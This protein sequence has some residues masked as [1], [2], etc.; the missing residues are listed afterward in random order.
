MLTSLGIAE[1]FRPTRWL[2]VGLMIVVGLMYGSS[3]LGL[4]AELAQLQAAA[5]TITAD[6]L[7][8]HVEVL[9]DD[10][11]EGRAAGS[12][13]GYA[14]A[15]Y[16]AGILRQHGL[17]PAGDSGTYF[18]LF[19]SGY[20][21]V[22]ALLPGSDQRWANQ[23]IVIG[24][25]YDHVG[26]GSRANSFGPIGYIHNGADDNASGVAAVLEL[27][28]AYVT[29][30]LRP[31]RS[32]LFAFWDAEE[33]GLLG[34]QYW[35][36]QAQGT[37]E[38]VAAINLDMVGRLRHDHVEVYG[39]RSAAGLRQI[40]AM[41]NSGHGLLLSFPWEM[42]AN[43]DHFTFFQHH[44]PSMMFHTGLHSDYH[45]PTD[46]VEKINAA[47]I[48]KVAQLVLYVAAAIADQET[49][50][51][52]RPAAMEE[53]RLAQQ[54]HE[55]IL[56]ASPGRLGV[57]WKWVETPERAVHLASGSEDD[58]SPAPGAV[59]IVEVVPGSAAERAGLRPG[60]WIVAA[61]DQRLTD[62]GQFVRLV[63]QATEKIQLRVFQPEQQT[64]FNV[65]M[66]LVGPP[67]RAGISWKTNEAE[68]GVFYI[69]QVQPG[70]PADQAGLRPGD[71]IYAVDGRTPLS[72][73]EL[74]RYVAEAKG[75]MDVSAERH[76]CV[77]TVTLKLP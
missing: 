30:G 14:A 19:Q 56:P 17:L 43:S 62:D 28:D 77:R 76:G 46:D 2:P 37:Y 42:K 47:G 45:R 31:R 66:P 26:F 9:A 27:V 57:R 52:F 34:S 55:A 24:A 33:K 1:Y 60:Q 39:T 8:H 48:A 38:I 36:Q 63:Y 5:A 50:L 23:V 10:T 64:V 35:L 72:S 11:F 13:G 75:T 6:E 4:A 68:P 59:Q 41:A 15:N 71:R 18:Q 21:N 67:L 65:T 7:R 29:S 3:G 54:A 25:H 12:R 49:Q 58:A 74:Q 20:R 69:I 70:S 32:V 53:D 61:E 22:L 73:D 16:L 40:V 51:S 44:I